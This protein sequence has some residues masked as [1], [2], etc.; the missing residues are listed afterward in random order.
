MILHPDDDT[1]YLVKYFFK[2]PGNPS[3]NLLELLS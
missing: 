3:Y 1:D 2:R